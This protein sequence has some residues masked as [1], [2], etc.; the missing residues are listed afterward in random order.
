[1]T[2]GATTTHEPGTAML[3]PRRG[4]SVAVLVVGLLLVVLGLCVLSYEVVSHSRY[5]VIGK[6]DPAT[7]YRIEYTVSSRYRKSVDSDMSTDSEMIEEWDYR[8]S[9]PPQVVQWLYKHILRVSSPG[10][11]PRTHDPLNSII[12]FTY[13]GTFIP[14]TMVDADG[15]IHLDTKG[16]GTIASK[17]QMR[18][19]GCPAAWYAINVPDTFGAN[20]PVRYYLLLLKPRDRPVTYGFMGVEDK[21]NPTGI[22]AE[23]LRMRYSIRI[24]KVH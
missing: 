6:T 18:V 13:R 19:S 20:Q 21:D 9:P 12:Q 1:M 7:G 10:R 14:D 11:S 24:T 15:Y 5:R 3:K 16:S 4:R 22:M 2:E 8:A 17:E 23:L